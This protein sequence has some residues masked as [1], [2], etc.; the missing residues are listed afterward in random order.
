MTTLCLHTMGKIRHII[1]FPSGC[2][3]TDT[4]KKMP[5]TQKSQKK[6][7]HVGYVTVVGDGMVS[8]E[9]IGCIAFLNLFSYIL[10]KISPL[11]PKREGDGSCGCYCLPA[12]YQQTD[13]SWMQCY[14]WWVLGESKGC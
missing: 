9:S 14:P 10:K 1:F 5:P 8:K 12:G 11:P 2:H 3:I 6:G 7:C 4:F 13:R